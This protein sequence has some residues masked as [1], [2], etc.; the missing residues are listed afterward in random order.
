MPGLPDFSSS[1]YTR[2]R[3]EREYNKHCCCP[4][5][6]GGGATG[7][8]GATGVPGSNIIDGNCYSDYL[9]WD[10]T[11]IPNSWKNGNGTTGSLSQN[12]H[13]GCATQQNTPPN[14]KSGSIAIGD[15]AGQFNQCSDTSEHGSIAI[16]PSTGNEYQGP[17]AIAIGGNGFFPFTTIP[18]G[19]SN[20]IK[21]AGRNN[22]GKGAIAIGSGASPGWNY[23]PTGL[24]STDPSGQGQYSISIGYRA[25]N[26]IGATGTNVVP[27]NSGTVFNTTAPSQ[28]HPESLLIQ[29]ANNIIINATESQ[30]AGKFNTLT[31]A[32]DI[33]SNA[34][35]ILPIRENSPKKTLYYNTLTHEVTYSNSAPISSPTVVAMQEK[36]TTLE[37]NIDSLSTTVNALKS[38]IELLL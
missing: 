36:I 18:G 1:S 28:P 22:Q 7:P 26:S 25:G 9:Y 23:T 16:G 33:S 21:S 30:N 10:T 11:T 8:Q 31:S 37:C 32:W 17:N 29:P 24:V 2:R 20:A 12:I 14:L 13:I 15:A 35:Y 6:P 4:Q 19:N 3:R 5:K 27:P 38:Q 34:C